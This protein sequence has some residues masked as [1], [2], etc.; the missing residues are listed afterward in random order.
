MKMKKIIFTCL[1]LG[2]VGVFA[3][4]SCGGDAQ[5]EA[6]KTTTSATAETKAEDGNNADENTAESETDIKFHEGGSN[7]VVSETDDSNAD[8]DSSKDD[9]KGNKGDKGNNKKPNNSNNNS[10]S[11][12]NSSGDSSINSDKNTGDNG[13]IGDDNSGITGEESLDNA[14]VNIDDITFF[15]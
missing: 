5:T 1:V 6:E 15:D 3:A 13:L 12:S 4:C 10:N 9:N 11:N 2:L 7:E 8:S 14:E